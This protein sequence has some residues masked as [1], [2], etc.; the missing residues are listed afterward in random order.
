[1]NLNMPVGRTGL[2]KCEDDK[3]NSNNEK[4]GTNSTGKE[5]ERQCKQSYFNSYLYCPGKHLLTKTKSFY[6]KCV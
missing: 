5:N 4:G 3:A 1:M 2:E 6:R